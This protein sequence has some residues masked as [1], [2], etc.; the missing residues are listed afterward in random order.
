MLT[1]VSMEQKSF[2]W[3]RIWVDEA[4]FCKFRVI[5]VT[6]KNLGKYCPVPWNSH[7]LIPNRG[8][9]QTHREYPYSYH[10]KVKIQLAWSTSQFKAVILS[11]CFLS[12]LH[13]E[14]LIDF[15]RNR[16]PNS[17]HSQ[18]PRTSASNET[19]DGSS[20]SFTKLHINWIN[21]CCL[22]FLIGVPGECGVDWQCWFALCLAHFD[23][24]FCFMVW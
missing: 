10:C 8:E 6:E 4:Y 1:W 14:N 20:S 18:L 2:R 5:V 16:G 24:I 12:R 11:L 7:S 17:E 21:Y 23:F 9:H 13:C 19:V 22:P 15:K 3:M